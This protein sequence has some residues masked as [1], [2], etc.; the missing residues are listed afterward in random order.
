MVRIPDLGINDSR[1]SLEKEFE[2]AMDL[3]FER[4]FHGSARLNLCRSFIHLLSFGIGTR[5]A[6]FAAGHWTDPGLGGA[7]PEF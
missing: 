7:C 6:S 4:D 3:T 5:V 2:T 1:F